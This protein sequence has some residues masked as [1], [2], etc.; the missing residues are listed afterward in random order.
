MNHGQQILY[1]FIC[2]SI[3][4]KTGFLLS[5]DELETIMDRV[6]EL[7]HPKN[8]NYQSVLCPD[9]QIMFRPQDSYQIFLDFFDKNQTNFV[10]L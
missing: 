10:N 1:N 5:M 9:F 7:T 3:E 4:T 8:Y 6:E 2:I